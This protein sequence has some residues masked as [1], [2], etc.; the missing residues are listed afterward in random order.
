MQML[1]VS[2]KKG[3]RVVAGDVEFSIVSISGNCVR[4]GIRAP[5]GVRVLRGELMD[6]EEQDGRADGPAEAA[7]ES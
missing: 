2:R 6:R 4:V 3:T 5:D 1:V 7:Q